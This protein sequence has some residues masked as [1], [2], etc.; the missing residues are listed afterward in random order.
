M[1]TQQHSF[2]T[3]YARL[4]PQQKKAVDTIEGPVM[5]V[6]GPGTGKT[7]VLATRIANILKLQD[8]DPSAILA[9][10]F[11]D[12]AAQN[13]RR[14]VVSLIGKPGYY[15][16]IC[17][18]HSF[19]AEVIQQNPEYFP[20]IGMYAV[21]LEEI[22]KIKIFEE[23]LLELGVT[24]L[25]P[26][27]KP[28]LYL[29]KAIGAISELKRENIDPQQLEAIVAADIQAF[30]NDQES[31]SKAKRTAREK[32]LAKQKE[33]VTIFTKYQQ[34]LSL[35]N[36]Y[37]FEDMISL[38]ARAF[39][40]T[41][42]LLLAYQEKFLYFLVDEYQDTNAAQNDIVQKLA[43]HW[44]DQA[45][46]FV[47]GD[48]H[49][50]IYRFQGASIE[51]TLSFLDTYPSAAVITLKTGYR[52]PQQMYDAAWH[53]ITN[54]QLKVSQ[55]ELLDATQ[56]KLVSALPQSSN[57]SDSSILL[58]TAPS[59]Q[60]EG[61][62]I[63]QRI[64]E[65]LEQGVDPAEIA[66]LCK[67]KAAINE[68]LPH[69][70]AAGIAYDASS[71]RDALQNTLVVQL[72][73]LLRLIESSITLE[74][75]ELFYTTALYAWSPISQK[76]VLELARVAAQ[77]KLSLSELLLLS[78]AQLETPHITEQDFVEVTAF[79][80]KLRDWYA[81]N[82]TESF[83]WWFSAVLNEETPLPDNPQQVAV[84]FGLLSHALASSQK[85][86]AVL[87]LN[88]VFDFVKKRVR[89]QAEYSLS[90][91][92]REVALHTEHSI[93][94]LLAEVTGQRS[95]ISVYTVH[96]AKGME[97]EHVFL[98]NCVNGA[99]GNMRGSASIPLPA[100]ILT[101][102]DISK[103]EKNEDERR[104]FYVAVTRAKKKLWI[105]HPNTRIKSGKATESV[106]SMF[107]HEIEPVLMHARKTLSE[108]EL[109]DSVVLGLQQPKNT[110]TTIDT[111]EYLQEVV[112][113]FVFS[114][115]ALDSYLRD[116]DQFLLQSILRVPRA[117]APV[118]SYGTAAHAALEFLHKTYLRGG[119]YPEKKLFLQA[120]E[121]ALVQE[122]LT[123]RDFLERKTKGLHELDFYYDQVV[124]TP[125]KALLVEQ[126]F[127]S[128]MK[129]IILDAE[130]TLIKLS[131]RVDRIDILDEKE[132]TVR[133]VDYKTTLAKSEGV[134]L[135]TTGLESYSERELALPETIRGRYHR[136]LVFYKLL[137]QLD[138]TF[139]YT[140]Q[141]G[142]IDFVM[143]SGTNKNTHICRTFAISQEAVE[144]LQKL[145][146]EVTVELRTLAFLEYTTLI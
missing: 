72:L 80:Q 84:G 95:R 114:P 118:A 38:V 61:M 134:I 42:D 140:M 93:P 16:T 111:R 104:V 76:V 19:A 133:F 81:R 92:L 110:A 52:C 12:A 53:T 97:W 103:K 48:P 135:G 4:N 116:P 37:D 121:Q 2:D 137:S 21:P 77:K 44:E 5:V 59:E 146:H 143:A 91:F 31:L 10:T 115:T 43:S 73:R 7:Q 90:D 108:S 49:Q 50:S 45:N 82:K 96:K 100:S 41:E 98:Y 11:T 18:F 131:G 1:S 126:R 86:T 69:L 27:N 3:A 24:P 119:Q 145:L 120:F 139:H 109:L 17:T 127:G 78:H 124:V 106:P 6:A 58:Y 15:V 130:G 144:D 87:A 67:K 129:P 54:N 62:H 74:D 105:S 33:L 55:Q 51:N 141:E 65:L 14:R 39:A 8:V 66:V 138:T 22:E 107:L 117:K 79:V 35:H 63:A 122:S 9:L 88:T 32:E 68:L 13:M 28:L 101:N 83:A 132:K 142:Q 75:A 85:I 46:I 94:L 102:T 60:A 128:S 47:V 29:S 89:Q 20:E 99:W 40:R 34:K 70:D 136:Q 112:A 71:G 23:I 113:D 57:E 26:L 36:R 64:G 56:S 123:P 25:T 125:S 30:E